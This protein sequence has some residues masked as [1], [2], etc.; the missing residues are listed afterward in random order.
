MIYNVISF[1]I[2]HNNIVKVAAAVAGG[3]VRAK[4]IVFPHSHTRLV[5]TVVVIT[6]LV[7][8]AEREKARKI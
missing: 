6:I 2:S 7:V 3:V 8:V 5:R 4:T 1:T